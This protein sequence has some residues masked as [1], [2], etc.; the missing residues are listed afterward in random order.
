LSRPSPHRHR[1]PHLVRAQKQIHFDSIRITIGV[2]LDT[3]CLII[4]GFQRSQSV[5]FDAQV[6]EEAA[7]FDVISL[8][9]FIDLIPLV[10]FHSKLPINLSVSLL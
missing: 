3:P 9:E 7:S 2:C 4:A 10:C 1:H 5:S 8:N 6:S